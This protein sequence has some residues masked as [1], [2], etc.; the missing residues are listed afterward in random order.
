[1]LN[2]KKKQETITVSPV[3]ARRHLGLIH[4]KE[5]ENRHEGL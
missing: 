3:C 2:Q 1:M 5:K 4:K